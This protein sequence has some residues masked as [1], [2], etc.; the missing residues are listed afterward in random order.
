[1]QEFI[2]VTGRKI[3]ERDADGDAIRNQEA[4]EVNPKESDAKRR[5]PRERTKK[6]MM[7]TSSKK[8]SESLNYKHQET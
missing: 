3:N 1:M 4:K 5:K 8:H 7:S 6:R 2:R